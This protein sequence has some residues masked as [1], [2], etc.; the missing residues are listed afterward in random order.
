MVI[1]I[2]WCIPDIPLK[3]KEKI[4][5]ERYVTNEIIIEQ[6]TNQAKYLSETRHEI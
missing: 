6:E 5:R 1:V 4:Q 3:L 2:R